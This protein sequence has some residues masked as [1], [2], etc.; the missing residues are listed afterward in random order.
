MKVPLPLYCYKLKDK[1]EFDVALDGKI[2]DI[3]TEFPSQKC[4]YDD[5]TGK[6]TG[7]GKEST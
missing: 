5:V 7:K 4:T 3:A 6:N 1:T 2:N